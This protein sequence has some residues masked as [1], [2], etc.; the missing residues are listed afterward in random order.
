MAISGEGGKRE[1]TATS[2]VIVPGR[3]LLLCTH[4]NNKDKAEK[5]EPPGPYG[6]QPEKKAAVPN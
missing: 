3:L 4:N 5:E 2:D 1:P 6:K